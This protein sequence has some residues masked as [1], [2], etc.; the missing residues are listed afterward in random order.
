MRYHESKG[1]RAAL[2]TVLV[3]SVSSLLVPAAH[4]DG[5]GGSAKTVRVAYSTGW[6]YEYVYN[7]FSELLQKRK[8]GEIDLFGLLYRDFWFSRQYGFFNSDAIM[9]TTFILLHPDD[10]TKKTT[11]EI[12]YA[13]NNAIQRGAAEVLFP[14]AEYVK[15]ETR[16]DCLNAVVSGRPHHPEQCHDGQRFRGG[17]AGLAG[18]RHECAH[19]KAHRDERGHPHDRAHA[20]LTSNHRVNRSMEKELDAAHSAASGSFFAV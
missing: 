7:S 13:G 6:Q 5:T 18:R 15:C 10:F 4:A 3:L 9:S 2:V 8:D 12:A 17:C 19:R 11:Q 14:D 16:E 20:A 1:I